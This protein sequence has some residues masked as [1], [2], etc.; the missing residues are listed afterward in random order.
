[1]KTLTLLAFAALSVT[2]TTTASAQAVESGYPRGT[3][4]SIG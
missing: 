4:A 2:A 3:L 1:M